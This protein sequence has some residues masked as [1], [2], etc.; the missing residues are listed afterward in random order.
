MCAKNHVSK[1]EAKKRDC[2]RCGFTFL[3]SE[4]IKQKGLLVCE[5]CLDEPSYKECDDG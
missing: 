3:Y 1:K 2:D 5:D 4:L